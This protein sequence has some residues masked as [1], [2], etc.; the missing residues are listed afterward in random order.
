MSLFL[1]SG[2]FGFAML[3]FFV[4]SI[5]SEHRRRRTPIAYASRTLTKAERNYT[6][7]EK[8]WSSCYMGSRQ[9]QRATFSGRNLDS[10]TDHKFPRILT[11]ERAQI[12]HQFLQKLCR[13]SGCETRRG[14]QEAAA[15]QRKR[16][17]RT[18]SE[19]PRTSG[20]NQ[21]SSSNNKNLQYQ[22]RNRRSATKTS[23][24]QQT[25][26]TTKTPTPIPSSSKPTS[27]TQKSPSLAESVCPATITNNTHLNPILP[28]HI[29]YTKTP[30]SLNQYAQ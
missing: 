6:T 30:H 8:E 9:I 18:T 27:P 7:T 11:Y 14:T 21:L 5:I 2:H 4:S 28:T 19:I 24:S 29:T 1:V 10:I 15:K 26:T 16:E 25:T 3:R 22:R 12:V 23:S 20:S 13:N 17:T